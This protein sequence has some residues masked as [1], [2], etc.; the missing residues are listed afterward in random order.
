LAI[1]N[2]GHVPPVIYYAMDTIKYTPI[3]IIH[4]PFK[5]PPGTPIQPRAAVKVEGT[6]EIFPEYVP[7][8]KDLGGV[9]M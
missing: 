1:F 5:E 9:P 8:L 3:G 6:A 7:G 2:P 4:S